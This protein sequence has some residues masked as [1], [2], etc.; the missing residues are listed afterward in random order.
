M[1][2]VIITPVGSADIDNC[3][4]FFC[5]GSSLPQCLDGRGYLLAGVLDASGR[6]EKLGV[7]NF[8]FLGKP[9]SAAF[10]DIAAKHTVARSVGNS[11]QLHMVQ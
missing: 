6:Q 7:Q 9:A 11:V 5:C 2:Y 3:R 8:R 10:H 1:L 4:I